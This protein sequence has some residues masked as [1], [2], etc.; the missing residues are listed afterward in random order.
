M[1]FKNRSKDDEVQSH[2]AALASAAEQMISFRDQLETNH[3]V[4]CEQVDPLQKELE[5]TR[6]NRDEALER[7]AGM[8]QEMELVSKQMHQL[9]EVTNRVE[10]ALQKVK[11]DEEE[12]MKDRQKLERELEKLQQDKTQIEAE[13]QRLEEDREQLRSSQERARH[14]RMS[15]SQQE[16][17]LARE[18][19][20]LSLLGSSFHQECQ[21]RE[22]EIASKLPPADMEVTLDIDFG[23][24]GEQ[25]T[26]QRAEFQDALVADFVAAAGVPHAAFCIKNLSPG[27]IIVHARVLP[28]QLGSHDSASS[29]VSELE[30]QAAD[31]ASSL[32]AGK[33]T[34]KVKGVVALTGT[35]GSRDIGADG[36]GV[37]SEM[38]GQQRV[39]RA[40]AGECCAVQSDEANMAG[41]SGEATCGK[42]DD[43]AREVE[44]LKSTQEATAHELAALQA[45]KSQLETRYVPAPCSAIFSSCLVRCQE[46]CTVYNQVAGSQAI[47]ALIVCICACSERLKALAADGDEQHEANALLKSML[48]A[49]VQD[50]AQLELVKAQ[51]QEVCEKELNDLKKRLG[52]EQES[53][54]E[55]KAELENVKSQ[56]AE[57]VGQN[58][59]LQ[60]LFADLEGQRDR[61]RLQL[62]EAVEH[63]AEKQLRLDESIRLN[64]D[65]AAELDSIRIALQEAEVLERSHGELI[66]A[67][68]LREND[69]CEAQKENG[70]L[71]L[72]L[73]VKEVEITDLTA[74]VSDTLQQFQQVVAW[75]A[76]EKQ[77]LQ[78][79]LDKLEQM[80]VMEEAT[81][82]AALA[83]EEEL[84]ARRKAEEAG[85]KG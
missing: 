70:K 19:E 36:S 78:D 59:K 57:A 25:G 29:V 73:E 39:L 16:T 82:A 84:A 55:L 69:L 64:A 40:S 43:S 80:T 41:T 37:A 71:S 50:G 31:P 56:L 35:D 62:E 30:R 45:E 34:S 5:E 33:L 17:K 83:D 27:S 21:S 46:T 67:N 76:K 68:R 8:T 66:A 72:A 49:A 6:Q 22:N 14:L 18:Q 85:N 54:D 1:T 7:L 38:G 2:V 9:R 20:K 47:V 15:L 58:E 4:W 79:K 60:E 10:P 53:M 26:S 74:R 81:E 48:E 61:L 3:K 63:D 65:H 13:H 42:C 32:R 44:Q 23:E 77:E 52:A 11:N 51:V 12:L 24:A 75:A 28:G